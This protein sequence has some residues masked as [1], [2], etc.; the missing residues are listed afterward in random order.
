MIRSAIAVVLVLLV[1]GVV[2][3]APR[4]NI[5]LMLADDLSWHD[6]GCYGNKDVHTPNLDA[7]AAQGMRFDAC[8]TG[9][10]MCA[11]T[12]QQLYT[13]VFPVRNGAYPN[14]S[15]VKPGTKSIVHHLRN[16]GYRIALIGKQHV[17]PRE[18]FPYEYLGAKQRKADETA[19]HEFNYDK[20]RRFIQ[21]DADEPYCLIVC[22]KQPHMPWNRG[23]RS[24]YDPSKFTLPP[25]LV[26]LP[27][28]RQALQQYYAEVTYFDAQVGHILQLI[29]QAGR[30]DNTL[31][32]VTSEQGSNFP[33]CKW[34]CYDTGLKTM[35]IVRWPGRVKPG[36]TT[37]AMV[38]YVDILPTLIQAAGGDPTT[39]DTG[40]PGAPDGGRG[41][42][43]ASFLNVLLG[44]TDSHRDAV[45]GV[46]TTQGII[47][48]STYPVRSIRTATHKYILN[49][50][51]E[52]DF[53][54]VVTARGEGA[55]AA[56]RQAA[57]SGNEQAQQM[58]TRYQHRPAEELYDLRHDPYELH[59]IAGPEHR[60]LMNQ[61]RAK[62][63]AW[64]KQQGDEGM[65]T[66][67]QVKTR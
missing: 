2:D 62:L 1:C 29:Q 48:G 40:L 59:N 56:W 12:R 14:H 41:F 67:L 28:T 39:V 57:A 47:Q 66:E 26:D 30:A 36:S 44:N 11:P 10:A 34:T 4:P 65:I 23:D 18:S 15:K 58:V 7:L 42:D 51:P 32:M 6:A 5:L 54:N 49:L 60:A 21:R 22:S 27:E 63:Q 46:H 38:Q 31:V 17:G 20:A 37:D 52:A 35:L 55:F 43:G 64:M 3:A 50:N 13:G 45:F 8:F 53:T 19:G 16:L 25:Y 33:H 61:L 24:V 9:T